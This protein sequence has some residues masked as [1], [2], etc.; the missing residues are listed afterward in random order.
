MIKQNIQFDQIQALKSG[1]KDKLNIL[2]YILSQIKNKEIEK[3]TD[4]SDEEVYSVLRKGVKEL[5]ESIESFEKAGR[6]ELVA[7][8]KKQL[9]AVLPYLPKELSDEEITVSIKNLLE[10]NKEAIQR[11]PK[12]AIGICM[13]ELRTKADPNR[14]MKILQSLT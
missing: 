9:D 13:K 11:N 1:D 2:R 5:K 10:I 8:Y 12:V 7:E 14:I 3:K 6:I 4:L